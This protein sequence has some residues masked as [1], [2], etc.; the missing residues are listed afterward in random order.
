[1][2]Q[3]LSGFSLN[4]KFY[5][6]IW[7]YFGIFISPAAEL[8]VEIVNQDPNILPSYNLEV[9]VNDTQC[10]RDVAI[11]QFIAMQRRQPPIAGILGKHCYCN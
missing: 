4:L 9:I 1:M 6:F 2:I 8:A 7:R 5:L 3:E 11:G 10:K